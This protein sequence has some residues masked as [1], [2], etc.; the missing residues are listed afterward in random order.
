MASG[1]KA[2]KAWVEIH[3]DNNPLSRALN[4]AG[5]QLSHLAANA[6]TIGIATAGIAALRPGV[7]ILFTPATPATINPMRKRLP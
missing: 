1:I 5:K 6:M 4:A 3:G 2:G 7:A